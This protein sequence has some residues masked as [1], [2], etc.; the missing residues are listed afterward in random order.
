MNNVAGC[1]VIWSHGT[2]VIIEDVASEHLKESTLNLMLH[3]S[4]FPITAPSAFLPPPRH[5]HIDWL[6]GGTFNFMEDSFLSF[7]MAQL[8]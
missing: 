8:N 7:K 2:V 6:G 4:T 1:D 5:R 3:Y